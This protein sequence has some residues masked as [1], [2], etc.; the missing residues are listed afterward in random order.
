[1]SEVQAGLKAFDQFHLYILERSAAGVPAGLP[2]LVRLLQLFA[3]RRS[4]FAANCI[5]SE[6]LPFS[7]QEDDDIIPLPVKLGKDMC[8]RFWLWHGFWGGMI[9]HSCRLDAI[10]EKGGRNITL[11][12]VLHLSKLISVYHSLN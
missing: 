2:P 5:H 1:M 11:L 12:V 7:S 6:F 4:I 3:L 9:Y 8:G 10:K